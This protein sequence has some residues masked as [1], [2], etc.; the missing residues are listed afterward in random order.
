MN[1]Y[2]YVKMLNE[3]EN[4]K[5]YGDSLKEC[6]LTLMNLVPALLKVQFW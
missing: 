2:E 3:F 5:I 1:V 6:I 4:S